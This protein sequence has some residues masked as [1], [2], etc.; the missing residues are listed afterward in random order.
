[1]PC[2][3]EMPLLAAAQRQQPDVSF[4][5]ANQGE[6]APTIAQYLVAE[7]LLLANV[8]RDP[9]TALG[10]KIGSM[11]LP[12]TLFYDARG[13]LVGTHIGALSAASLASNLQRLGAA[14][15]AG[16]QSASGLT[17]VKPAAGERG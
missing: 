2:R 14:R 16:G 17:P 15:G 5:F 8:L 3:R 10:R 9:A 6:D 1:P 7:Q 12:T 11:G 13:R 4:V